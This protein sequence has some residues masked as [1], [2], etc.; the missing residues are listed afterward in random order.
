M[1][2]TK[3]KVAT[4]TTW[5][6][7]ALI[8][9]K[10][11]A[12]AYF[13]YLARV[14][15]AEN[16]GIYIF[17]LSFMAIFSIVID[18]GLSNF[19]TREVAKEQS[20]AQKLYS[21]VLSFKVISSLI[22]IGLIVF[23][24]NIL[25]YPELTRQLVYLAAILMVIESLVL[26][27][28]AIVRGYHNLKY[29]SFG[30]IGVQVIVSILGVT[31]LQFTEDIRLLMGVLIVGNLANLIYVTYL[32]IRKLNLKIKLQFNFY[33][34]RNIF[35]IVLPFAL[36]AGFN[37]IYGAFDQVLLSK[38]ASDLSLGYYAVAYKLT[39]SLQFLPLALVAALYP[40][41]STYY[42]EDKQMLNKSFTRAVYYL[43]IL[44]IP[45]SAGIIIL[46]K[47]FVLSLYT[48]E[49]A[50]SILPLQI[51]ISS[52]FFL[53]INFPL[54]SLLNASDKQRKNTI[55]IAL[56]MIFNIVM[57]V[58][59]IPKHQEIGAA[60]SS[61]ISTIFLFCLGIIAV[62]N[63]IK[64]DIWYLIKIFVK[65]LIVSLIMVVIIYLLKDGLYWLMAAIIGFAVYLVG[66][67]FI[68]TIKKRDI[69]Q[70]FNSFRRK[71]I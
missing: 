21:N 20:D 26:S 64:I 50:A 6:T 69:R 61:T 51:L 11:I 3:T 28:F 58:V 8:L 14:L 9:Q 29:E 66:Q 12:F 32:I 23:F 60:I 18:F 17:A 67:V 5:F 54:G 2:N 34:W 39:F 19:I 42:K 68:G 63:I 43:I 48:V 57:N 59:L 25:N 56:A 37:K 10:L 47:E 31:V 55:N 4:N 40:A 62:R 45:L 65:T 30:T 41:M 49:F 52:L 46:A 16:L 38:L 24:I 53:F 70:M 44:T 27:S 7:I 1:Y 35:L 15:G 33:Y 22:A 36:A 71:D 13:T